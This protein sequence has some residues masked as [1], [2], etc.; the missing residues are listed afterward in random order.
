MAA[1]TTVKVPVHRLARIGFAL[2]IVSVVF[3]FYGSLH[4]EKHIA[5]SPLREARGSSGL[6]A[7]PMHWW[8]HVI[9][10]GETSIFGDRFDRKI[11][12]LT[13]RSKAANYALQF[14]AFGLPFILGVGAAVIGGNAMTAIEKTNGKTSGHFQAVFAIMIGGFAAIISGCMILSLYVW[15][16]IPSPY[17][18]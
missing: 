15:P 10:R 16:L 8:E 4:S 13:E 9:A 1:P 3:A 11:L 5:H 17:T 6:P 2:S 12:A 14:L 7:E 18:Q